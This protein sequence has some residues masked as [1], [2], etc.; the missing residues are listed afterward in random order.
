MRDIEWN[1]KRSKTA[2]Y[3]VIATAEAAGSVLYAH[4]HGSQA[5]PIDEDHAYLY[6]RGA[7]DTKGIIA[8]MLE[9]GTAFAVPAFWTLA[10]SSS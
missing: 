9:A 8:A 3:N 5:L 4:R 6:G 7:C 1:G 10:I 2:R